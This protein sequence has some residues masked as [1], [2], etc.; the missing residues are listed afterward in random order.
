MHRGAEGIFRKKL[1]Q[2]F[3]DYLVILLAGYTYMLNDSGV[4]PFSENDLKDWLDI[5]VIF[6]PICIVPEF[7]FK[8]N[9]YS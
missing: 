1:R 5:L 2:K 6:V 4:N 3:S 8:E 9:H 7:V